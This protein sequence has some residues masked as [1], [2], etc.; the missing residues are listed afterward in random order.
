MAPSPILNAFHTED[1]ALRTIMAVTGPGGAARDIPRSVPINASN[2]RFNAID[3]LHSIKF[4]C[5]TVGINRTAF[6]KIHCQTKLSRISK[7]N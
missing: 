6:L 7:Y 3:I 5:I 2:K 1:A 4:D